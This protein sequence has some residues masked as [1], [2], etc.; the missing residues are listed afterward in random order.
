[1]GFGCGF[2]RVGTGGQHRVCYQRV[3]RVAGVN[4]MIGSPPLSQ[5]ALNPLSIS[6]STWPVKTTVTK[7]PLPTLLFSPGQTNGLSRPNSTLP[8][9]QGQTILVFHLWTWRLSKTSANVNTLLLL[10]QVISP[11]TSSNGLEILYQACWGRHHSRTSSR[12]K[13]WQR[14]SLSRSKRCLLGITHKRA[15]A[16]S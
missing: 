5:P 7:L 11:G 15:K 6:P 10:P 4:L 16:T 9:R 2:G 13:L 1:M 12:S 3:D 8:Q 14:R